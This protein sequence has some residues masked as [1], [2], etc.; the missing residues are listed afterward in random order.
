MYCKT[1]QNLSSQKLNT[2]SAK[3]KKS[4]CEHCGYNIDEQGRRLNGNGLLTDSKGTPK[5]AKAKLVTKPRLWRTTQLQN[6]K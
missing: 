6:C 5:S 3:R 4:Q 1:C 2:S